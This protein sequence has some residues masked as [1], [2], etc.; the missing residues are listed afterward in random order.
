M[1]RLVVIP[2]G[3]MVTRML[4]KR[5]TDK[6]H[7]HEAALKPSGKAAAVKSTEANSYDLAFHVDRKWQ[8][9]KL[10]MV[11]SGLDPS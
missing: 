3:A 7:I 8:R 5:L 10:Y 4:R 9:Y 6:T 11:Q 2:L 1:A